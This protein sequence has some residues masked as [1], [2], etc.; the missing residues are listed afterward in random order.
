[1]ARLST[2]V[3]DTSRGMPAAGIELELHF[4][5][6][7]DR[8][9]VTTAITNADGR[10]DVPLLSGDRIDPGTYELKFHAG[11]YFSRVGV[12]LTDPPFLDLIVIRFGIADP[13]GH[14]H[15][16][17]LLSPYGYSTYRGS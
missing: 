13:E 11:A 10:T 9:L 14:Y 12:P 15:V 4:L 6:D 7:G 3:L 16:P 5:G 8:S 2:H 1:M 17:L